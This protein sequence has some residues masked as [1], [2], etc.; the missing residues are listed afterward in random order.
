[1]ASGNTF[2]HLC[3]RD[4]PACIACSVV[5]TLQKLS[6]PDWCFLSKGAKDTCQ[7]TKSLFLVID[8]KEYRPAQIA[9]SGFHSYWVNDVEALFLIFNSSNKFIRK[10][11]QRL[12][13]TS[14][15]LGQSRLHRNLKLKRAYDAQNELLLAHMV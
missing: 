9:F 4:N 7:A 1:M 14:L 5:K 11:H 6:L 13:L 10:P 15:C 3:W 12:Y 8:K 2:N